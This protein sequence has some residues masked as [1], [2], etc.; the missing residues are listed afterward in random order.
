MLLITKPFDR[1]RVN[2]VSLFLKEK[3]LQPIPNGRKQLLI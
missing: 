1:L 2:G 3:G